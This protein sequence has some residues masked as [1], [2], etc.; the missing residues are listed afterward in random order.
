MEYNMKTAESHSLNGV[1]GRDPCC[2]CYCHSLTVTCGIDE[3]TIGLFIAAEKA[4][5]PEQLG[6]FSIHDGY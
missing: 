4:E 6:K 1:W 2:V 5:S 3:G